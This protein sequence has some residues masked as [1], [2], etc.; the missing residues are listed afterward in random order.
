MPR[1]I[2]SAA[3]NILCA[4]ARRLHDN[5]AVP[6]QRQIQIVIN[7]RRQ[8]QAIEA[9]TAVGGG[10]GHADDGAIFIIIHGLL[11][12][13]HV[14]NFVDDRQRLKSRLRLDDVPVLDGV[15]NDDNLD[16]VINIGVGL[17][18]GF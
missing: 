18:Y 8:A 9:G 15:R 17:D 5:F 6:E 10:T 14:K 3:R 7:R 16:V 11:H 1:Q 4:L 13:N 2:S 12:A